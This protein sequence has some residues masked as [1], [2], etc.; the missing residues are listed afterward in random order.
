MADVVVPSRQD[1]LLP[2]LQALRNLGG[3][4]SNDEILREVSN[5]MALTDSQLA[6]EHHGSNG[7]FGKV[8]YNLLWSRTYLKNAGLLENP[9]QTIWRLTNAGWK[10]ESMDAKTIAR[11][12]KQ[13]K[14]QQKTDATMNNSTEPALPAYTDLI[15]PTLNALRELGG[16]ARKK[17]IA[18]RVAVTFGVTES[19]IA[20]RTESGATRYS[21]LMDKVRIELLGLGLIDRPRAGTWRLTDKGWDTQTVDL[22]DRSRAI[23]ARQSRQRGGSNPQSQVTSNS[24]GLPVVPL[25]S[26]LG[27]GVD[28]R[29]QLIERLHA[30]NERPLKAFFLRIFADQGMNKVEIVHADRVGGIEGIVSGGGFLSVR[31]CFRF[32]GGGKLLGSGEVSEFRSYASASRADKAVFITTGKFTAE[33]IREAERASAMKV[34]PIDGEQFISLMKDQ[35][36]GVRTER[37]VVERTVIDESWFEGI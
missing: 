16:E 9:R 14:Q 23:G 32:V 3:E 30:L 21:L 20:S 37:V 18:D 12:A 15:E 4:G 8:A 35:G 36:M 6:V 19:Q 31:V 17:D 11:A 5:I 26:L 34:Q 2:T 25:E 10:A 24:S 29:A 7:D 1:L 27:D 22:T 28:W 33:G 13:N